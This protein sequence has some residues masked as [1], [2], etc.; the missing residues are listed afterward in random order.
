MKLADNVDELRALT[1]HL[2]WEFYDPNGRQPKEG[3]MK[4]LVVNFFGGPGSGK[5]TMAAAVFAALKFRNY[6]V[7]LVREYAKELAWMGFLPS[8]SQYSIF[9]EQ[10][11]RQ[12]MLYGKVEAIITDSPLLLSTFY[13]A[14]RKIDSPILQRR[15]QEEWDKTDNLNFFVQRVKPYNPAGRE[16]TEKEAREI[17]LKLMSFMANNVQS[18]F[19]VLGAHRAVDEVVDRVIDEIERR[20]QQRAV[21]GMLRRGVDVPRGALEEAGLVG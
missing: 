7:E 3:S 17:D 1:P 16:Q 8:F 10:L 21:E 5:S 11:E 4:P 14:H 13:D 12:E 6:N 18:W 20:V 2:P 19:E 15:V 9:N